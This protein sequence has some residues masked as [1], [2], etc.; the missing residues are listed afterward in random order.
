MVLW[1]VSFYDETGEFCFGTTNPRTYCPTRT[2]AKNTSRRLY[3][4]IQSVGMLD[5][6]GKI[7]KPQIE[8]LEL[9]PHLENC[10]PRGDVCNLLNRLD[11]YA[12]APSWLLED[13]LT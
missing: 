10:S 5:E 6:N 11:G 9:D 8:K 4:Y 2:S 7:V 3:E 12:F 1:Q 13:T